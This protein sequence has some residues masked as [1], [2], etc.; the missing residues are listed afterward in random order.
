M[1]VRAAL[2]REVLVRIAA[3]GRCHSGDTTRT[4]AA[5]CGA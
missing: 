4:R 3:A 5:T 2:L 1:K